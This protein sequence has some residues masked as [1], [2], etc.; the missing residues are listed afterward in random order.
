M[1][2]PTITKRTLIERIQ[3]HVANNFPND[4]SSLTDKQVLLYVDQALAFAIV[5][6]IWNNAKLEGSIATPEAYI[7]TYVIDSLTKDHNTNDW[8]GTLPQP[9]VSLPLGLSVTDAFF[10]G[11]TTGKSDMIY[12]IKNK[13]VSFRAFMPMPTGVR[14]WVEGDRILL[15]ASNDAGLQGRKLYV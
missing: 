8:Y 1:S 13:R 6:Q 9:P 4:D 3:L 15:R 5:G 12:F 2:L 11:E 7:S 10:A 14:A